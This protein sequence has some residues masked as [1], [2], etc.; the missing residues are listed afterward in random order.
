MSTALILISNHPGVARSRQDPLEPTVTGADSQ[1]A[2]NAG[3]P[4]PAQFRQ[5]RL[6][7]PVVPVGAVLDLA[8]HRADL[9]L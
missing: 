2:G 3:S 5:D 8:P 9:A 4:A 1:A 7:V 6:E